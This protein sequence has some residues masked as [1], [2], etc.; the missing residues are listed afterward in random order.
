MSQEPAKVHSITGGNAANTQ[1]PKPEKTRAKPNFV[2]PSDRITVEKQLTLLRGFAA[3]SGHNKKPVKLNE[4]A[5]VSK[6]SPNTISYAN[7]FFLEAGFLQKGDSGFIPADEVA[8]F[9]LAYEWNPATAAH[10]LA[11]IILR[12]W[13]GQRLMPRLSMGVPV[14]ENELI[15]DLAQAAAVGPDFRPRVKMVLEFLTETGIA[16]RE[17]EHLKKGTTSSVAAPA[18]AAAPAA[19]KTTEGE[20]RDASPREFSSS[21]RST[22]NTAFTQMTGGAVQFN[23]TVK[24]DMDEFKDW[25]PDRITA[26]FGGIAAVLSAKAAVQKSS[27]NED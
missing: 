2:L 26:F 24:V 11:P 15:D 12:S 14:H 4:V 9:A 10:K 3:V 6:I 1:S 16:I 5:E 19:E 13:F 18:V 27:S 17:G 20:M 23:I 25:K 22:V 8:A 21:T 7:G